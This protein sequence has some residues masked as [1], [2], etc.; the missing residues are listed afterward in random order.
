MDIFLRCIVMCV[1]HNCLLSIHVGHGFK[2]HS[3]RRGNEELPLTGGLVDVWPEPQGRLLAF[4]GERFT[5]AGAVSRAVEHKVMVAN[6]FMHFCEC[7]S[8]FARCVDPT[9]AQSVCS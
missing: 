1:V 5:K 7:V 8:S 2:T 9:A 6:T 4:F 3:L